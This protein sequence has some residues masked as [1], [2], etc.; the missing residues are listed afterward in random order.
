MATIR[1]AERRQRVLVDCSPSPCV[2]SV[3]LNHQRAFCADRVHC[4]SGF[5]RR[6]LGFRF[7]PRRWRCP[8]DRPPAYRS[9]FMRSQLFSSS[10]SLRLSSRSPLVRATTP[11]RVPALFAASPTASTPPYR[12]GGRLAARGR[13]QPPASVRPQ[14]FSTS[15]RLAPSSVS[16]ACFI[17]QP[18]PGFVS[19][20]PGVSPDPQ[21]FPPR[22][23][24][25]PPCR[26]T[27]R[28]HR[29]PGCHA[30][31][32]GFEASFCGAMRSEGSGFSL[33]FRRSPLRLPPPAG[34]GS[35]TV[36]PAS[37]RRTFR[38]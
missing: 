31:G 6:S 30:L 35:T 11:A 4:A 16:R 24:A 12:F 3:R 21:R 34:S 27:A 19:R 5:Q 26:S 25:L 17:P 18:R 29:R 13:S 10:K 23:R 14:V 9:G 1:L 37:S 38:S 8:V 2:P 36:G 20:R 22:R 15:R 7:L 33:P 32:L 28:A